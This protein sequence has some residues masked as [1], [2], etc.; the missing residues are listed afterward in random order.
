MKSSEIVSWL[1]KNYGQEVVNPGLERINVVLNQLKPTL[2]S[3]KIITVAGT[4]GKGETTILLSSLLKED[5]FCTWIS[6]HIERINERFLSEDG[7]IASD[8][9][10]DLIQVTHQ[11]IQNGKIKLSFYEFLFLVFCK[12][13]R[14]RNPD[15]LILEVGLGGRLDAVNAFDADV[16]LLPS[17]S[18]DH[19]EI[20][21][22]RYDLILKEKLGV[23]RKKSVLISYLSLKYLRERTEKWIK[24]IGATHID[25]NDYRQQEEKNFSKRNMILAHAAYFTVKN[26]KINFDSLPFHGLNLQHRGEKWEG[27]KECLFYGSHNVDGLRKLIQFLHS[28]HYNFKSYP[29]DLILIAFSRRSEKDL[30]IMMRMIKKANLG[31]VV[32]TIFDHPKAAQVETIEKLTS[33]EGLEFA[34]DY[35]SIIQ[36]KEIRRMLVTGSYYFIGDFQLRYRGQL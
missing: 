17:I 29:F 25:L 3:K 32:V 5:K 12:W 31:R 18:R 1:L 2:E 11:E 33:Q 22:N 21:G 15:Y 35:H 24:D 28:E 30:L 10:W 19:Q 14:S 34:Q 8:I 7:E 20:L 9:L 36:G 6:P 26:R 23:C 13:A 16:V 27:S 4:N